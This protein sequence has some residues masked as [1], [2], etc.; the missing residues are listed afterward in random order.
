MAHRHAQITDSFRA[1][2]IGIY[3]AG[4]M[5]EAMIRGLTKKRLIAPNRIAVVNRSNTTRLEELQRRYGVAADNSPEGKSRL[6]D[7]P[8]A[9]RHMYTI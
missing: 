4:S 9:A 8:E 5:A 6:P 1:L 2:R 7:Y 3:G